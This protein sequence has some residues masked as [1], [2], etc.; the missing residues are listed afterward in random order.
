M[1]MFHRP[2]GSLHYITE[3]AADAP[4]TVVLIHGL[5]CELGDWAAQVATLGARHRVLACDLRGHG[6]SQFEAGFDIHT[7]AEDVSALLE[8]LAI[9]R[10]VLA[11]HSMGCRVVLETAT[12]QPERVCAAVLVDGSRFA[13]GDTQAAGQQ[14]REFIAAQG[15]WDKVVRQLFGDMFLAGS[16]P[17][18][19]AALVERA[20]RVP[21]E[22]GISVFTSMLS[23][24]AARMQPVL[25]TLAAELMVVQST[26]VNESR[27]RVSIEAGQMNPWLDFVSR[28]APA[29]R[30][31]WVTGV[32]HFAQIEAPAR[33][34]DLIEQMARR[35]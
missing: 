1:P 9:E 2:Q 10:A 32:G 23:W 27:E 14:A 18:Y 21:A 28:H 20:A 11:G 19:V 30:I 17:D 3:G 15:G 13:T 25:G 22:V 35:C 24:D 5:C 33:I 8:S 12:L 31:E 29:A 6:A 4:V 34:S 26:Y 16:D 7:C